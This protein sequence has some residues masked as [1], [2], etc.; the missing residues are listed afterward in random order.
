MSNPEIP[1][2]DS[3]NVWLIRSRINQGKE[4]SVILHEA[5]V[6]R[7]EVGQ[8]EYVFY[9]KDL[10]QSYVSQY[11]QNVEGAD[12][13]HVL[14][15]VTFGI[16]KNEIFGLIGPNGAGKSTLIN[17]ITSQLEQDSGEFVVN[18]ILISLV[19]LKIT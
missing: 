18:Q 8:S 19:K 16:K 15:G 2:R 5:E 7:L 11:N 4:P 3:G 14:N 6:R 12:V 9:C 13:K 1:G 17:V 10:M